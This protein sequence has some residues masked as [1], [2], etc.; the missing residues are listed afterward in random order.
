MPQTV[1]GWCRVEVIFRRAVSIFNFPENLS[2][3][4]HDGDSLQT[5]PVIRTKRIASYW[6]FPNVSGNTKFSKVGKSVLVK[7]C[8]FFFFFLLTR[9]TLGYLLNCIKFVTKIFH[10]SCVL[11][12]L[13]YPCLHYALEYNCFGTAGMYCLICS[14]PLLFLSNHRILC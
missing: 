1:I 5:K 10:K 14:R 7:H 3:C 9:C 4:G 13:V 12:E 6:T 8:A 2:F 11:S